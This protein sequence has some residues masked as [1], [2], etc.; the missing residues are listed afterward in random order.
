MLSSPAMMRLNFLFFNGTYQ[1][2]THKKNK[3][4]Y[5]YIHIC[6]FILSIQHPNSSCTVDTKSWLKSNQHQS[7]RNSHQSPGSSQPLF[8][9]RRNETLTLIMPDRLLLFILPSSSIFTGSKPQERSKTLTLNISRLIAY[10]TIQHYPKTSRK[11]NFK[12][13]YIQL[14]VQTQHKQ[15]VL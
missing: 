13:N 6:M 3:Y 5:V 12:I 1:E 10:N 2:K 8:N 11:H 7:C 9:G 4:I 15:H 14:H